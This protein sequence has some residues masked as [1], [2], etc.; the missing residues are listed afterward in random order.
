MDNSGAAGEG[1]NH[2]DEHAFAQGLSG[3][4]IVFSFGTN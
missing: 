4:R 2:K 3:H 1:K